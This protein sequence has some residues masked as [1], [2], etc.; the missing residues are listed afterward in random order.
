MC[1]LWDLVSHDIIEYIYIYRWNWWNRVQTRSSFPTSGVFPLAFK[2]QLRLLG[3][4]IL[5]ALSQVLMWR[6][7]FRQRPCQVFLRRTVLAGNMNCLNEFCSAH[8]DAR[9]LTHC[10]PL[11]GDSKACHGPLS[12]LMPQLLLVSL[13]SKPLQL[14]KLRHLQAAKAASFRDCFRDQRP[15]GH[16]APTKRSPSGLFCP[17]QTLEFCRPA[18]T[19][20]PTPRSFVILWG[21]IETIHPKLATRRWA[22]YDFN[23]T[24][25]TSNW[26]RCNKRGNLVLLPVITSFQLCHL[27]NFALCSWVTLSAVN[28]TL[29]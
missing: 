13:D 19:P 10:G 17:C 27:R 15:S 24:N 9:Q 6:I 18:W 2:L 21:W 8:V 26:R 22:P 4:W 11:D 25:H 3:F 16:H 14:A 5:V 29:P 1:L 28:S 23:H 7:L 12:R 20:G